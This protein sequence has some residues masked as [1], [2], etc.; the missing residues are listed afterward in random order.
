M[1]RSL[2]FD[3][4][5]VLLNYDTE[6][7]T[8]ALAEAGLP[9][10]SEWSSCPGLGQIANLYLNGL[11]TEEEFCKRID[12]F[13]RP[14]TSDAAKLHSMQAV[15]SDIPD[16]R[17]KA[18]RKLREKYRIYLLSNI[19]HL[20]WEYSLEQFE[21]AGISPDECFDKIFLS[22]EMGIAKPDPAV[23]R[24]VLKDTGSKAEETLF[25]DDSAENIAAA[26][27]SGI[28]T[29]RIP[30]NRPEVILKALLENN[31]INQ[32]DIEHD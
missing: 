9:G 24:R 14:G 31:G 21:K 17:L 29:Y 25:L 11:M 1:I 4:G 22:F 30:M 2:V 13:C 18:L 27:A 8:R 20:S 26:A 28:L 10:Y 12:T 7:D 5:G 6:A 19:N 3:L 15:L 16:S 32:N 23:F